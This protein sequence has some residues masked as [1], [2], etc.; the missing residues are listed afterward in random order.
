M[1]LKRPLVVTELP[2]KKII[3]DCFAATQT[4]KRLWNKYIDEVNKLMAYGEIQEDESYYFKY[5]PVIKTDMYG[6]DAR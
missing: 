3:A 1:W 6:S 5:A 2:R 4:D